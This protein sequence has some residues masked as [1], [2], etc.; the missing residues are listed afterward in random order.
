MVL[1][2]YGKIL[3]LLAASLILVNCAGTPTTTTVYVDREIL[4]RERPRPI[5][6]HQVVAHAVSSK[7]LEDYLNANMARNGD[8]AFIAFDVRY[9]ENLSL[10]MAEILRYLRQQTELIEYYESLAQK[11]SDDV[12]QR[13]EDN[14]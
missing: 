11:D 5:N 7:N 2:K 10:N 13:T 8:T 12:L 9:Y 1:N 14:E 6:L 3:S 4:L